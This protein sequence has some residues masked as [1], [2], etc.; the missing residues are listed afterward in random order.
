MQDV[1]TDATL[2]AD[3]EDQDKFTEERVI[4]DPRVCKCESA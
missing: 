3:T 4:P 2:T 1:D